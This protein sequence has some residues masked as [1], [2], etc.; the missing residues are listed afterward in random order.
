MVLFQ[1]VSLTKPSD[2]CWPKKR[3]R[4]PSSE[5]YTSGSWPAADGRAAP[6]GRSLTEGT[7]L[8]ILLFF[9]NIYVS[10][11]LT[12]EK[13]MMNVIYLK[14]NIILPHCGGNKPCPKFKRE[15]TC[16]FHI[17]TNCTF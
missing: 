9:I 16:T 5:Y 3:V 15:Q 14:L 7:T 6:N 10:S 12:N 2:S 11:D 8:L 17:D 13:F 1:S 4:R